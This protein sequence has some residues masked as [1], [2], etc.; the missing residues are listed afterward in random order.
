MPIQFKLLTFSVLGL[1]LLLLRQ[2]LLKW[3]TLCVSLISKEMIINSEVL[4]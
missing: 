3:I 2:L 1:L 4:T